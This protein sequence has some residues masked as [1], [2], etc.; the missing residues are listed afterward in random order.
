MKLPTILLSA[1][2]LIATTPGDEFESLW[3]DFGS[4]LETDGIPKPMAKQAFLWTEFQYHLGRCLPYV[5]EG[6]LLHWRLWW[7]NTLLEQSEMGK[8]ILRIGNNGYYE[9]ILD[10]RKDAPTLEQ[11]QRVIDGWQ[12]EM[13]EAVAETKPE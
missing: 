1:V 11:C 13:Q 4:Q 8:E 5:D 10:G 7:K 9:G 6:D 2:A 12:S 3:R